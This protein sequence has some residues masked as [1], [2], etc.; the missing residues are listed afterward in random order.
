MSLVSKKGRST[1]FR[2]FVA[3]LYCPSVISEGMLTWF[4]SS[5]WN[6]SSRFLLGSGLALS[7]LMLKSVKSFLGAGVLMLPMMLNLSLSTFLPSKYDNLLMGC[8]LPLSPKGFFFSFILGKVILVAASAPRKVALGPGESYFLSIVFL[9]VFWPILISC[10]RE[11]EMPPP[12]PTWWLY[13][14]AAKVS[15]FDAKLKSFGSVLY[16]SPPRCLSDRA[17]PLP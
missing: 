4:D 10:K 3:V 16:C 14:L 17:T 1:L 7:W 15:T 9:S 2:L 12:P 6:L 11:I 5:L 8:Q 13:R